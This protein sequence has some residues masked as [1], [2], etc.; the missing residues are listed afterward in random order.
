MGGCE[1]RCNIRGGEL[2]QY[3]FPSGVLSISQAMGRV[4]TIGGFPVV[5]VREK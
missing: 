4:D 2:D 1:L 5:Y 3:L